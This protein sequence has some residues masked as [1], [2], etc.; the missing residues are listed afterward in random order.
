MVERLRALF[1]ATERDGIAEMAFT[2]RVYYGF[3]D[4]R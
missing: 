4:G 3:L 2:T 1:D